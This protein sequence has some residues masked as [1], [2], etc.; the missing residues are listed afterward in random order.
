MPTKTN[1]KME[2][3]KK[4]MSYCSCCCGPGFIAVRIIA[5]IVAPLFLI[6]SLD[7]LFFSAAPIQYN[8]FTWF[9]G[10]VLIA[11]FAGKGMMKRWHFF[12]GCGCAGQCSCYTDQKK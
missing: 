4:S 8:L 2:S 1:S 11:L 3:S 10:L 12:G 9:A 5:M 6:W 7:T